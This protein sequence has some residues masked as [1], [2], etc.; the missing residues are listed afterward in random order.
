[1]AIFK[2]TKRANPTMA[3]TALAGGA[4]TANSSSLDSATLYSSA[5]TSTVSSVNWTSSIEL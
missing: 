5:G 2:I 3:Y 1:M 4:V